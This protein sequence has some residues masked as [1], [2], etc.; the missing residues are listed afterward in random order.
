MI[1][2]RKLTWWLVFLA[3]LLGTGACG[4]VVIPQNAPSSPPDSGSERAQ[5][6]AETTD[7]SSDEPETIILMSHDSF[8]ASEDVIAAFET[9]NNI[10]IEFL[11]AGD[12]GSALNQAILSKENP[13]ADVFFWSGQHLF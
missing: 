3:L 5:A 4:N 9:A 2:F 7:A 11:R 10:K 1:P 12:T 6:E 8:N 13:L